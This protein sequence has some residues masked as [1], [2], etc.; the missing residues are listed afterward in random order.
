MQKRC[1]PNNVNILENYFPWKVMGG[2]YL[3]CCDGGMIFHRETGY[4]LRRWK[5][6]TLTFSLVSW[7]SSVPKRKNIG[8]TP[9]AY[10]CTM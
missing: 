2:N 1:K 4:I 8:G 3:I 6:E 10:A 7:S 5:K 9:Y